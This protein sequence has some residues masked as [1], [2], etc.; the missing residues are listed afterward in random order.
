MAFYSKIV[1][2]P[3]RFWRF[4]GSVT[5]IT[6]VFSLFASKLRITELCNFTLKNTEVSV[7][8]TNGWQHCY[9]L[10]PPKS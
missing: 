5:G 2:F 9:C 1:Y 7:T 10:T 8:F 6:E 4:Q 3:V